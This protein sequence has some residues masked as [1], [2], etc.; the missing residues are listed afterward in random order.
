MENNEVLIKF[1]IENY[2]EILEKLENVKKIA[3]EIEN[4]KNTITL[5]DLKKQMIS[6]LYKK[7]QEEL[8]LNEHDIRLIEILYELL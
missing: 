6:Y 4:I 8:L 7:F 2:D 3:L 5:D 1:K